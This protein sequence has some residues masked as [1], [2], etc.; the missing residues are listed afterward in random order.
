MDKIE[1]RKDETNPMSPEDMAN[2]NNFEY[3]GTDQAMQPEPVPGDTVRPEWLPDKFQSPEEMAKAYQE[4]QAK[5]SQGTPKDNAPPTPESGGE[6]SDEEEY[7]S[8]MSPEALATYS[9]EYNKNGELSDATFQN[10]E[11]EYGI[12][13]SV[14]EAYIEG[15]KALQDNFQTSIMGEVGGEDNYKAMIQWATSTLPIEEQ[16]AFDNTIMSQDE[17]AIRMAVRGV[18]SRYNATKGTLIQGDTPSTGTGGFQS[19]AEVTAAMKDPRYKKDP[20]Y[21]NQIQQRLNASNVI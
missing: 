11:E 21:R 15:Q 20:A 16:K 4:L 10:I 2:V 5:M 9:E 6:E 1:I 8:E 18:W 19:I 14:A 3:E 13:R 7:Y 17:N 12:P